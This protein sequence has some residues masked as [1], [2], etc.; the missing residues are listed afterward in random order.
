MMDQRRGANRPYGLLA[1]LILYPLSTGP[2]TWLDSHGLLT[3]PARSTLTYLYW[4][5]SWLYLNFEP[6]E[7]CFGAYLDLWR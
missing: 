1:I 2:A 7:S 3:E 5:L 4:P 6:V